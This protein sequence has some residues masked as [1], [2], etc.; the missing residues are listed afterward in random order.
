MTKPTCL[1]HNDLVSLVALH[2]LLFFPFCYTPHNSPFVLTTIPLVVHANIS[3]NIFDIL[4]IVPLSFSSVNYEV[5][6]KIK[7]KMMEDA[8]SD[9]SC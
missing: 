9:E 8:T 2:L 6:L 5:I 3:K 4:A 7:Q 1:L